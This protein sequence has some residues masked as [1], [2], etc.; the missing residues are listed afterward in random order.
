M[1]LCDSVVNQKF[2][3]APTFEFC[4]IVQVERMLQG[5]KRDS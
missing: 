2:T 1:M 3:A 5:D 4:V